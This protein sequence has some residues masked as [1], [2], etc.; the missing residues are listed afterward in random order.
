MLF[1]GS[2]PT[3][4]CTNLVL[5]YTLVHGYRHQNRL[6]AGALSQSPTWVDIAPP[7][8]KNSPF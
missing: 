1:Y 3:F 8:K 2:Y 7:P 6:A 4:S 5:L